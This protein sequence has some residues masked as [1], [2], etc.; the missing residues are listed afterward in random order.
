M[1]QLM[2]AASLTTPVDMISK[3]LGEEVRR[4]LPKTA[5]ISLVVVRALLIDFLFDSRSGSGNNAIRGICS[6]N[7]LLRA[8]P[9]LRLCYRSVTS[10]RRT[11]DFD[12][13]AIV[14]GTSDLS[15]QSMRISADSD[16]FS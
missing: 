3:S 2:A 12:D 5:A 1:G 13:S 4:R 10:G 11:I 9:R 16:Y 6:G 8:R 7:V 14:T 15:D